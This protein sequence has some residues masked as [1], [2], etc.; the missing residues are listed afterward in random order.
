M[1]LPEFSFN[2]LHCTLT[3]Y[4]TD[5]FYFGIKSLDFF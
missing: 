4:Y 2:I 1:T 3:V 5:I